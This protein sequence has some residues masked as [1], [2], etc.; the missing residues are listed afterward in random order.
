MGEELAV[1]DML[2]RRQETALQEV[3]QQ[4][5]GGGAGDDDDDDGRTQNAAMAL[6]AKIG[7]VIVQ[8]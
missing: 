8:K 4:L 2:A 1:V 3:N 7:M 5:R 6:A